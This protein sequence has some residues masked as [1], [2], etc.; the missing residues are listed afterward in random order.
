MK[1]SVYGGQKTQSTLLMPLENT[2]NSFSLPKIKTTALPD[3]S[4]NA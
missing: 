4:F 3:V 2:H 1:D